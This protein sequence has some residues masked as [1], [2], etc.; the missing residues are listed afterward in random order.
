MCKCCKSRLVSWNISKY[1][2]EKRY[3]GYILGS[4]FIG[5]KKKN[6]KKKGVYSGLGWKHGWK[7]RSW[8]PALDSEKN[9]PD[10]WGVWWTA[11]RQPVNVR[12]GSKRAQKSSLSISSPSTCDW[13]LATDGALWSCDRADSLGELWS[14]WYISKNKPSATFRVTKA[15]WVYQEKVFSK[16]VTP[17]PSLGV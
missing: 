1:Q 2:K 4:E 5:K 11:A 16:R 13:S 6:R 8:A 3:E 17:N 9:L 10:S 14:R 15:P 7:L 12:L